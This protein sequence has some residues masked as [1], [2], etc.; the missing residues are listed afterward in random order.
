MSETK[1]V[2]IEDLKANSSKESCYIVINGQ[3]QYFKSIL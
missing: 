2:T 1:T 3:G